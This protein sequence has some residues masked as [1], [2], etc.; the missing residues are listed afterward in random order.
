MLDGFVQV[1][2]NSFHLEGVL[3]GKRIG[4]AFEK[5]PFVLDGRGPVGGDDLLL[6]VEE[7]EVGVAGEHLED[8][9]AFLGEKG[10]LRGE[11]P[12]V[13]DPVAS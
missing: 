2:R 1:E 3:R 10:F 8:E 6:L 9:V 12:E 5:R 4:K 13:E 11:K 7:D